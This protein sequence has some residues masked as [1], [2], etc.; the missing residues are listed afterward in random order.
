[1]AFALLSSWL[2]PEFG[3]LAGFVLVAWV[4]APILDRLGLLEISQYFRAAD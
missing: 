3:V 4:A 2:A 1:M